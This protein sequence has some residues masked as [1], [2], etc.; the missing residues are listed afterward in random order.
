MT[1]TDPGIITDLRKEASYGGYLCL[2]KILSAQAPRSAPP[3]HD[4]MLFIIIHQAYELWFKLVLHEI[5]QTIAFMQAR[6]PLRA[7]H[8]VQRVVEILRLLVRQIH[9]LGTLEPIDFLEFRSRLMPASGFQ[10][11]QFREIEFAAGLK[12]RAAIDHF[13]YIPGARERLER[14]LADPDLRSALYDMLRAMGYAIPGQVSLAHLEA[15]PEASEALLEALRPIYQHPER[16]L[17]I[18]L[19]T[20]A[21]LDLDQYLELWRHHHVLVVERIIGDKSGTGG[22]SGVSYL[23]TTLSRHCFPC[24][25]KLR[26]VLEVEHGT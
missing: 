14:R 5:E 19:L 4:E 23:R 15:H 3:H 2:D 25:W 7:H 13:D 17:P 20:E 10:S 6:E 1:A 26:T 11:L 12:N 8:F 24:L 16:H 21:L 22:S 9:I 18:H